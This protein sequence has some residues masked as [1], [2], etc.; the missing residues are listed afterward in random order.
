MTK[1]IQY[2]TNT[3]L[4][5]IIA[6]FI[7]IIVGF[8][9]FPEF[10]GVLYLMLS[11]VCIFLAF[12]VNVKALFSIMPYLI[13]TEIFVRAYAHAIP[14]LFLQYFFI[15]I[16]IILIVKDSTNVKV[17]SRGFI[18]LLFFIIIEFFNGSR[19]NDPD[20]AR[21]LM[22][23]SFALAIIVVWS[24]FNFLSPAVVN[25][26]LNH[27]KYA[28]IY[29]CG[30]VLT[31]YLVG[32]VEFRASSG[33]EGTNGLAPVQLSG[34]LGFSCSVFFFAIMNDRER[35]NLLLNLIF[36]SLGLVIMLLSFSRGGIYFVGIIMCLYF[37]FNRTSIKSY[38]LFLLVVPFALLAY[39]YASEKTHGLIE[40]R[41]EQ[42]GSSGRD[43]LVKAGWALFKQE[44]LVGVGPA[45]FNTEIDKRNLYGVQSGAHNEFIR[46]A[47]EDGILGMVTYWSFFIITFFTIFKRSKLR[48]EYGIYFLI[49]FCLIVVHNGLKISLQP[50]LMMLAIATPDIFKVK[51][52]VNVQVRTNAA[53]PG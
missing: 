14:Y 25:K 26:I 45:N 34:Y 10:V 33:S 41:Y 35:R 19:S 51:K 42:E 32:D 30:I 27:V 1:I 39:Y 48:R 13:Y 16:F 28:G 20:I 49:F 37:L 7:G 18:F 4:S 5:Y 52:K 29:L 46:V 11:V 8:R 17:H 24:S 6:F 3:L 15:A 21:G 40:D 53:L 23:N 9:A 22:L 44:P 36:F 38:F 47:A 2:K 43:Q 50:F 12:Q 31:R